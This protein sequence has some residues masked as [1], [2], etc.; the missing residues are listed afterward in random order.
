M[1][2]EE[3]QTMNKKRLSEMT[4]SLRELYEKEESLL[5]YK[6]YYAALISW[7]KTHLHLLSEA[8]IKQN[9]LD[10][11]I[12][13]NPDKYVVSDPGL[14]LKRECSRI[15]SIPHSSVDT[16]LMVVSNTL[17][18]LV[19]IYSEVDCP[20]CICG[21]L[22]YVV[23]EDK[24]RNIHELLLECECGWTQ[25]LNGEPWKKGIVQITPAS[26]EDINKLK[27]AGKE[28]N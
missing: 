11:L 24:E 19:T 27:G 5:S 23:A 17:W 2:A 12:S 14:N 22:Y 1:M 18:E 10:V 26:I 9:R 20:N 4:E 7:I 25:S 8:Q 15:L 13:L 6:N 3:Y 21:G 28:T 16:L